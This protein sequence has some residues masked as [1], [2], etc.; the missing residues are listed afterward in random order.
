MDPTAT[1]AAVNWQYRRLALCVHPDKVGGDATGFQ[2]LTQNF[3]RLHQLRS[4]YNIQPDKTQ[5][6][7]II[8][9]LKEF[10]KDPKSFLRYLSQLTT[11][12]VDPQEEKLDLLSLDFIGPDESSWILVDHDES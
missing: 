8:Q 4:R 6:K 1:D 9:L 11:S 7:D 12:S 10:L 5:T 3:E 2:K